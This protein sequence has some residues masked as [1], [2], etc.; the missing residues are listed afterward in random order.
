MYFLIVL[1]I[2]CSRSRYGCLLKHLFLICRWAPYFSVLLLAFHCTHV[3]REV[4]SF[5]IL[6]KDII[7]IRLRPHHCNFI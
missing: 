5:I 4:V 3:N 6:N 7:V 1:D 2:G